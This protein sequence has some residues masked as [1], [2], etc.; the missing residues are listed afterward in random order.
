MYQQIIISLLLLF[1]YAISL[2]TPVTIESKYEETCLT[3]K[4]HGDFSDKYYNKLI[5]MYDMNRYDKD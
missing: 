5:A 1:E 4:L 3:D 2:D